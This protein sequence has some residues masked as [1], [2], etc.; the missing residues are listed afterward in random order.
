MHPLRTATSSHASAL[1]LMLLLLAGCTNQTMAPVAA[2]ETPDRR[3]QLALEGETGVSIRINGNP[4][5]DPNLAKRLRVDIIK[6]SPTF[7]GNNSNKTVKISPSHVQADSVEPCSTC[8]VNVIYHDLFGSLPSRSLHPNEGT[9]ADGDY[10][11]KLF[12]DGSTLVSSKAIAVNHADYLATNGT[13]LDE[14]NDQIVTF[15]LNQNLQQIKEPTVDKPHA[16]A[17]IHLTAT[18]TQPSGS[19]TI[20]LCDTLRVTGSA[21]NGIGGTKKYAWAWTASGGSQE[22]FNTEFST[23]TSASHIYSA[24]GSFKIRLIARDGDDNFSGGFFGG[25]YAVSSTKTITVIGD[26]AEAAGHNIPANMSAGSFFLVGMVMDNTGTT[27]WSSS[28][29]YRLELWRDAGWNPV[30]VSLSSSVSP[31]G[32][33]SFVFTLQAPETEG[34]Y[35]C[36]YRMYHLGVTNF[37]GEANGRTSVS[38]GS[39]FA[40]LS[41]SGFEP[42]TSQLGFDPGE[43][44]IESVA[45][46]EP[47]ALV[48]DSR[49]LE[50]GGAAAVEYNYSLETSTNID[51]AFRFTYDPK[52]LAPAV[53]QVG[54]GGAALTRTAGLYKPG[55]YWIRLKGEVPA[56]QGQIV[57]FP[58]LLLPG[59][60]LPESLGTVSVFRVGA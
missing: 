22:T 19:K 7:A 41:A 1:G 4:V 26:C 16:R 15:F 38:V 30:S 23:S 2:P 47:G 44:W 35:A 54:V 51:V 25:H 48:L 32:S 45:S 40:S 46:A 28:S 60:S 57:S 8:D 59:A 3:L 27:T 33:E 10:T 42:V 17:S 24:P 55:E 9:L 5:N 43:R 56:G 14:A 53:G 21:S 6:D 52:V 58:F 11:V 39:G 36:L 13:F 20:A 18:I 31:G 50:D 29:G 49:S 12:R 34:T 37:F